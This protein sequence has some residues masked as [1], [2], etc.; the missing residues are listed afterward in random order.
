[1]TTVPDDSA[2]MTLAC[3]L[4]RNCPVSDHAYPVG[5]VI[6]DKNGNEVARAMAQQPAQRTMLPLGQRAEAIHRPRDPLP[7]IVG[8][9]ILGI[10]T[11]R[12]TFRWVLARTAGGPTVRLRGTG[13][14]CHASPVRA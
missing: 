14:P 6:V 2:W 4:A 7:V 9:L 5:A 11:G 10:N 13:S 1:M 12:A 8:E 3:E